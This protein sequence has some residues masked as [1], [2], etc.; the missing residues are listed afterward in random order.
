MDISGK[1]VTVLGAGKSGLAAAGLLL[2]RGAKVF[3]SESKDTKELETN[4]SALKQKGFDYETGGHTDKALES[5]DLVVIS[6]GIPLDIPLIEKTRSNKIEVI[7]ELEFTS[8]FCDNRIIA[9]TGTNGKSTTTSMIGEVFKSAGKPV[10]IAGNIGVAFA[11]VVDDLIQDEIVVLEVSSYQLET[12]EQFHPWI[13]AILN[14]QPDHLMRHK[15]MEEYTR[16]K[17]KITGNQTENDLAILNLNDE[18]LKKTVNK[19]N[20]RNWWFSNN[21]PVKYGAGIEDGILC[22]YDGSDSTEVISSGD[23]PLPGLHNVDNAL[24]TICAAM[25]SG[26]PPEEISKGLKQFQGLEHR[27]K[28]VNKINNVTFI[29]DSKATNVDSLIVALNSFEDK[30][31]LIAGGLDK[32][33]DLNV[34]DEIIREKVKSILLIGEA[35]ERMYNAWNGVIE[36]ITMTKDLSS[37]VQE[38]FGRAKVK[39]TI[40]FSPAC[41][42]FDMF[43]NFEE[44]GEA[45]KKIVNQLQI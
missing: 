36:D 14:I 22:Y 43:R 29:N 33:S 15:T 42:S 20:K 1:H 10:K 9:I 39:D 13:S 37:A 26:L 17:F 23:L 25:F 8:R 16:C 2:R 30:V 44:R 34:A 27:L 28:Y 3:L 24:V 5:S 45:F 31:I 38:A 11:D 6:P 18:I 12:V 21:S 35:A 41:A 40:L 4:C 19:D 32:G 7:G